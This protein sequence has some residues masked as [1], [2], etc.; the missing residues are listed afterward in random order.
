[1]E[2]DVRDEV[3]DFVQTWSDRTELAKGRL[4]GWLGIGRSRY[5]DWG[6]RYG[7]VNEHNAWIPRDHW[8]LGWEREAIIAG[9]LEH[10]DEGYR[11]LTYRLMDADIVAV[12]PSSVYRVLRDADLLRRWNGKPS[13]KG[14][15]FHQPLRPHEHWHVDISYINVCGTFY[16]L[17]SVLDG[18]S[19]Y[20]VHWEIRESMTEPDVES[21]LQRAKERFPDARPRVISD[22]GP[23]FIAKD[24]KE[25]IR[26]SGMTHVRTSPYYPQSNGKQERWHQTLKRESIR[27]KTPLSL[28]DA[29]RIV[30]EFVA[31]YN[32]ERLHS[33]IGY[34]APKDQ[35]EG[36]ADAI[37]AARERKLA[38]AREARKARRNKSAREPLTNWKEASTIQTVGETDAGTAGEQPARDTRPGCR[39]DAEVGAAIHRSRLPFAPLADSPECLKKTPGSGAEPQVVPAGEPRD[40]E[41]LVGVPE[42]LISEPRL[43]NSR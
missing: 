22:N 3:I 12:S 26:V 40:H 1:V 4:V 6:R 33:A 21:I 32:N 17:L 43:S 7:R 23:Q 28:D 35:L 34:I 18:F 20:I 37:H 31:Y 2:P 15:G 42:S 11:R 29:R 39:Q 36:R 27:P 30:A 25:F 9:Y 14:T 41:G 19:R 24:F 13:K 10:R 5:Y 16:Y 38:A 8:L